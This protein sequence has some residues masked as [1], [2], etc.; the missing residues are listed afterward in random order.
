MTACKICGAERD[1][2]CESATVRCNV[3]RFR[4]HEFTVWRCRSCSSIHA[5]EAVDLDYYYRGY[6]VLGVQLDWKLKVTYGSL[7]RRLRRAGLDYGHDIL[8]HGCGDGLLVSF[9]VQQGYSR[10]VGYD[11]YSKF[12]RDETALDKRYDCI[13][14]QDV[15][16]HVD[17]PQSLL[18][19]F[20]RLTK[21]GGI[22]SIGTP[23]AKRLDLNDPQDYVHALHQPFHRHMFSSPALIDAG[24]K[25]G[26]RVHRFY[27]TMYNNTLF[28]TM[29]PRFALHYVRCYDDVWDLL[30][31]PP[32][33][34]SWKIWT[35]LTLFYALFGYFCDRHTDIMVV[36]KVPE[37]G[38]RESGA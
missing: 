28:P 24:E 4:D 34:T 35:P 25:L 36:F 30:V 14:S 33:F 3:R 12:Y 13:V 7:L 22:I 27:S 32:R 6:P 21:P 15:I 1:E 38:A 29:N 11:P 5:S 31:E 23:D 37:S 10:V 19:L 9:L 26:W 8:D 16:E 17:D 18:S 20:A 2:R